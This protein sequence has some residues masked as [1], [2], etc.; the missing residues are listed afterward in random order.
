MYY[1]K[2][3]AESVKWFLFILN[4]QFKSEKNRR[5][6]AT[7]GLVNENFDTFEHYGVDK[8][9]T[10][11]GLLTITKYRGRNI[12]GQFLKARGAICKE[13][14]IKLTSTTFT[15]DFSNHNADNVGFKLDIHLRYT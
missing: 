9:L 10:S 13:F 7:M 8:Y 11:A 1:C 14:A 5:L 3:C 15:S 12:G 6:F 4:F 2:N